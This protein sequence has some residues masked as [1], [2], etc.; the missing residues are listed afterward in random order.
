MLVIFDCD[1]VLVD[2][3][4]LSNQALSHALA[5]IGVHLT[6]EETM[7]EFMGRSRKHM[8][9]RTAQLLGGPVPEDFGE[10]YDEARN[11]AFWQGLEPV[12]GIEEALDAIEGAGYAT[13]VA[14]SGDHEKMRLTLGMTGLHDRFEGR[15]YSATEVANGKPAPDLFLHAAAQMGFDPEDCVVVED[16]PAGVEA[17][18][19]AGM[20]V[21]GFGEELDADVVFDDMRELPHLL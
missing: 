15:I 14:S 21:L 16:A 19:A 5:E 1:G 2:S 9:A 17:G 7:A 10:H 6:V 18:R 11:A 20:R 13:C 4:L 8:L 12:E 3:E